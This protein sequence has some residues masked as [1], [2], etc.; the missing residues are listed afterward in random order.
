MIWPKIFIMTDGHM[1]RFATPPGSPVQ[2]EVSLIV[3]CYNEEEVLPYLIPRLVDLKQRLAPVHSL[4]VIF[5]DDGSSDSTAKQLQ[6]ATVEHEWMQLVRHPVNKGIAAA[7]LTGARTAGNEIL[8]SIDADCSYDPSFLEELLNVM[9]PDIDLVTAS[10]YHRLGQVVDVP[11]WRLVLS[12]GLSVLYGLTLRQRLATYTS[13]FRVYRRSSIVD[14]ELFDGGFTG[15]AEM[16]AWVD[17]RGGRIVEV[18][19]VLS[20]RAYGE[21]KMRIA[22]VVVRHLRLLGRLWLMKLGWAGGRRVME[23]HQS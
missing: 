3:P 4:E 16:L 19:A 20:R 6:T 11:A 5:V 18:P 13:C 1:P 12:R 2:T 7:I 14:L 9:D 23:G 17:R 10:P 21:S 22:R 8:A 15:I